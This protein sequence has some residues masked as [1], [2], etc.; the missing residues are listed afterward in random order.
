M[1]DFFIK[2]TEVILIFAITI[3]IFV[4]FSDSCTYI[5]KQ[6]GLEDD[7]PIEEFAEVIINETVDEFVE[8]YVG[9]D[10]DFD[11]DLS[12]TTPEKK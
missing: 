6:I 9:Y 4:F 1:K 10:P 11:I 5:N 7:N 8:K 2:H 3:I 12:P